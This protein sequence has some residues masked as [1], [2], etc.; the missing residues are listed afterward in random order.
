M[1]NVIEN[2]EA[3]H[4]QDDTAMRAD[5]W[6]SSSALQKAIRRGE[7]DI[8]ARAALA[9]FST[10][11]TGIFRRFLV[12][13]FE[14]V[15][16]ADPDAVIQTVL[17]CTDPAWRQQAGGNARVVVRLASLL[18]KAAKDR[19]ADHLICAARS[20]PSLADTRRE[21]DGRAVPAR[22]EMA[23]NSTLRVT[24]RATAAWFA[25]GVEWGEEKR[26]GPGDLSA[27]LGAFRDQGAP[28][29]LLDATRLAAARTREPITIMVPLIWLAIASGP[30]PAVVDCEVPRSPMID[31]VPLYA[32]DVH[33]RMG[34][35]AIE[36]FTKEDDAIRACLDQHVPARSRR[37]VAY[38]CSFYADGA[39]VTP[40]LNW[41]Q[42]DELDA[43]GIETDLLLAG[44]DPGGMAALLAAFREGLDR[45]NI[46]RAR[47]L[48][49]SRATV[50]PGAAT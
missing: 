19:C 47:L 13:A 2:L 21:I 50:L 35:R 41:S 7:A 15:G 37:D 1:T 31:G 39:P 18:A 20:S 32:L 5:P 42:A 38:V 40:K 26:V 44:V 48:T 45:L 6:I 23:V 10:A 29:A 25:S 36:L 27:L 3:L 49:A 8:A 11:G 28:D 9:V 22:I 17:A 14:D 12:I 30:K 33:T 46:I 43:L 34:R 24:V 4:T 16:A